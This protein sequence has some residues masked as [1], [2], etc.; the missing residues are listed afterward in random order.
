MKVILLFKEKY[1]FDDGT[2]LEAVIWRVPK[3]LEHWPDGVKYSLH[4]GL[5]KG[6]TIVRYDNE[7]GK[8]H[9][10]HYEAREEAYAFRD[11]DTLI[12]DFWADVQAARRTAS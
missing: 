12:Q 10:R 6:E 2:I 4:Y 9:H 8:G 1:R 11:V 7:R 3:D 5:A